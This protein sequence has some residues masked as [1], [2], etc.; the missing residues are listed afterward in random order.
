MRSGIM[1]AA[2]PADRAE[3][4]RVGGGNGGGSVREAQEDG[5]GVARGQGSSIGTSD[6]CKAVSRCAQTAGMSAARALVA[7]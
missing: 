3:T 5:C 1:A 6:A 4:A 2:T 7:S